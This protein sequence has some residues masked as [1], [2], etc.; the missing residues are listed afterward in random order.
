LKVFGM[1]IGVSWG[2]GAI[3]GESGREF[4]YME[5]HVYGKHGYQQVF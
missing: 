3:R 1:E 2:L 4:A 5:R